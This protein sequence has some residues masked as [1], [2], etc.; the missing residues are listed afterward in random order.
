MNPSSGHIRRLVTRAIQG[1]RSAIE[2]LL[3]II[4]TA[5]IRR[6]CGR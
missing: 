3:A 4:R 6:T 5:T 2:E 1:D